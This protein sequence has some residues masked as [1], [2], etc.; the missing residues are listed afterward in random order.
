MMGNVVNGE[1]EITPGEEQ[2]QLTITYTMALFPATRQ[3]RF[4]IEGDT[5]V[6]QEKNADTGVTYRRVGEA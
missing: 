5:L 3:F 6:L 4:S 1:Y 2:H